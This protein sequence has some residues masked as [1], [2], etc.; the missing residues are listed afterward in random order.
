MA[1][2]MVLFDS[3]MNTSLFLGAT[4]PSYQV[5]IVTA[6]LEYRF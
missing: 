1:P 3:K 5:H 6:S 2:D 4:L